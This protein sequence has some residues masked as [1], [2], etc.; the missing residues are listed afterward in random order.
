MS[1]QMD[2]LSNQYNSLIT[3]YQDTYQE[4]LNTINSGNNSFA[5]IPN[6]AYVGGNNIS[7]SPNSSLNSCMNTCTSN[8]SCSGATFDNSSQ[9]CTLSSGVGNIVTAPNKTAI[10]KQALFYSY[11]LQVI[12]NELLTTNNT[13]SNIV[14]GS[15][16]TYQQTQQMNADKSAILQQNYNILNGERAQIEQMIREYETLNTAY[17][18]G[19]I[20][21]TSNYYSYIMYLIIAVFL[22]L[23]LLRFS[24][25]GGSQ[26]GGGFRHIKVNPLLFVMLA[27]II[28]FN[29]YIKK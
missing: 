12:N 21:T 27:I 15:A 22:F 26:S 29:A 17:D 6:T 14:N 1:S 25:G 4:F 3:Q 8:D 11:Q 16:S 28:I 9:S 20:N 18:N 5:S 13:M 24:V 7:V 10:V 23:L 19:A 2:M